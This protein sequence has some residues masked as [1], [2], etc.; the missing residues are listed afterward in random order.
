MQKELTRNFETIENDALNK[1]SPAARSLVPQSPNLSKNHEIRPTLSRA[2]AVT[3]AQTAAV[4]AAPGPVAG[5]RTPI[6]PSVDCMRPYQR[7]PETYAHPCQGICSSHFPLSHHIANFQ[8]VR[9]NRPP[10]AHPASDPPQPQRTC[11]RIRLKSMKAAKMTSDTRPLSRLARHSSLDN[12]CRMRQ[13]R[14]R[15]GFKR[16]PHFMLS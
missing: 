12:S 7:A 9:R 14:P 2:Q 11:R 16:W 10:P 1:I 6:P 8:L 4:V 5:V 13:S 15:H 3:T